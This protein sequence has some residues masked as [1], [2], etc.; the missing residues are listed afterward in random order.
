MTILEFVAIQGQAP[1]M[2]GVINTANRWITSFYIQYSTDGEKWKLYKSTLE[3]N[4]MTTFKGN[5]SHRK[6]L[7]KKY[8]PGTPLSTQIFRDTIL[9][10]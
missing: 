5:N 3:R 1:R 6:K 2:E 8:R 4:Y 7:E 9:K 10:I